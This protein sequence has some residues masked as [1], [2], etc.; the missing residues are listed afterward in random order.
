MSSRHDKNR[1]STKFGCIAAHRVCRI[2]GF[3]SLI[4]DRAPN[5]ELH[6][7]LAHAGASLLVA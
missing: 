6:T 3:N 1:C 2:D 7:A 4:T 5:T